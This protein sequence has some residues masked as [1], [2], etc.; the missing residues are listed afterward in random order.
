MRKT[1]IRVLNENVF[2]KVPHT[3]IEFV[4][5]EPAEC[6]VE[7]PQVEFIEGIDGEMEIKVS[8]IDDDVRCEELIDILSEL[9]E[10]GFAELLNLLD[11]DEQ[12]KFLN[13]V[14]LLVNSLRTYRAGALKVLTIATNFM[15][16][17]VQKPS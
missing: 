14:V 6:V 3:L 15:I 1:I 11:E 4:G 16:M 9:G 13:A 8:L 7:G 2:A 10:D 5:V 17:T 12:V